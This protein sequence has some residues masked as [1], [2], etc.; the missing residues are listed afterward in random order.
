MHHFTRLQFFLLVTLAVFYG[1]L[2]RVTADC[3]SSQ[4]V[5]S[6]ADLATAVIC[7]QNGNTNE[8]L[9]NSNIEISETIEVIHVTNLTIKGITATAGLEYSIE[10]Q[11]RRLIQIMNSSITF[12]YLMFLGDPVAGCFEISNSHA[13]MRGVQIQSLPNTFVLIRNNGLGMYL[14]NSTVIMEDSVVSGWKS[15]N[16][17]S[18]VFLE[19]GSDLTMSRTT[20]MDNAALLSG[21][22]A[23]ISNGCT[24][25]ILDNS[26][27]VSNSALRSGGAVNMLSSSLNVLWINDTTFVNNSAMNGG[28]L[29]VETSIIE[30]GRDIYTFN[31]N[32]VS[33]YRNSAGS[34]GGGLQL[35]A[36]GILNNVTCD[37]NS[38][39]EAGVCPISCHHRFWFY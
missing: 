14:L 1:L 8:I 11:R 36:G 20:F 4:T 34:Q 17:G 39:G 19:I 18:G 9:I 16:Q 23:Y 22:G 15:A 28:A 29:S 2:D 3:T 7:A 33:F 21:G 10:S 30:G 25:S 35:L 31:I 32:N 26:R 5:S 27:F 12:E 6:E 13:D 38:A 37:S 24:L